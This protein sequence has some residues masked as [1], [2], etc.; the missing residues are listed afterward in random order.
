MVIPNFLPAQQ[1][2]PLQRA[3]LA[4][5]APA[6]EMRQGDA[7][8][9]RMA[10]DPA[11]LRAVPGLRALL[12]RSDL[13]GLLHYVASHRGE[14]LHYIQTIATHAIAH[15]S[16]DT[17]P[18]ETL[19]CDAFH[20]SLKSWFFL[21]DLAEDAAPFVYVPGSHRLTPERL[22]WEYARSIR[23]P[24][25]QDRLSAR[26]SPRIARTDLPALGLPEPHPIAARANTLVVADTFGFHAR[27]GSAR[28]TERIEL[29][30]YSRRNPF[31]PWIGADLLS[32]PGL[33]ERRVPW[34]WALRDR[35]AGLVGQ[36]WKP[37]GIRRALD[38]D[39]P[40]G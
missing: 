40:A 15:A 4:Y 31:L 29:W 7:I 24:G 35:F 19:H 27:G 23:P 1:F 8:T 22:A 26:G 16:V 34:L 38:G 25:A 21:N 12:A 17:D 20:S 3:I 33:A 6:R 13:K 36:P 11:M 9:R 39:V 10:V 37:V 5:R 2:A 18:Q 30:S 28:P 14:P 32:L